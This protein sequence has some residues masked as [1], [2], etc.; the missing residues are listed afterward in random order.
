MIVKFATMIDKRI[1][2]NAASELYKYNA[3]KDPGSRMCMDDHLPY[4]FQVDR[5]RLLPLFKSM[6]KE[7][8]KPK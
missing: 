8:L 4:K 7:G 5:K 3:V 6:R 2:L 1:V